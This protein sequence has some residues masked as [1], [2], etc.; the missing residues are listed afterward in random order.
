[1]THSPRTVVSYM[2]N[3]GVRDLRTSP[4]IEEQ[5]LGTLRGYGVKVKVG[6]LGAVRHVEVAE[7]DTLEVVGG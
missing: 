3:P 1:M 7:E 4:E 5:Q 2:H 6:D